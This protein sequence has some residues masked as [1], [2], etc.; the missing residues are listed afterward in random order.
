MKQNPQ[1]HLSPRKRRTFLVL[2]IAS[3]FVFF[4]LLELGLR[5]IQYGPNLSLLRTQ[6]IGERAYHVMNPDVKVRYFSR[7]QFNP[8]SSQDY[9]LVPKPVGTFR[10][11]C[12]GG[13]TTVGFPY[14][15]IGSFSTFLRDRLK[16]LF[17]EK[18][19]EIINLGMTATN[20]FTVLDM[21]RELVDYQPDM[22]IVYDGHNEFYGALGIASNESLGSTR[23]LTI[24]SLKLIHFKSSLL[25]RDAIG[26]ITGV[27]SGS[28]T[29]DLGGTMMER[30]ARGQLVPY[31]ST[32]YKKALEIFKENLN[33][34]KSICKA[35]SI[36]L[37]LGS[38]VSNLRTQ[39]PFV[40]DVSL[41][42]TPEKRLA[43]NSS[44][45][46]G[47]AQQLNGDFDSALA[48]FQHALEHDSLHAETHYQVA[49]TLDT[50]GFK[51]K[52]RVEYLM[53]RD[54]DNLRFRTSS[55]FNEAIRNAAEGEKMVLVDVEE[56]FATNSPDSIPGGELIL[57]HLHPNVRGYF[58]IAKA[59][60]EALRDHEFIASAEEWESRDT[61]S[62]KHLW[63]ERTITDL[64]ERI[65]TR[66]IEFL[67]SGWPF[68]PER[69][70]IRPIHPDDTLGN[71]VEQ[72]V[73]S[74]LVWEQAHIEAAQY[75]ETRGDIA[76]AEQQY[77]SII[78]QIPL[79]V[80][81]YLSLGQ[82]YL[83]KGRSVDA[84]KILLAS[85]DIEKTPYAYKALGAISV[86][87][88][89]LTDAIEF[90]RQAFAFSQ[91]TK[92]R[93]ENGYLLALAFNRAGE[94]GEAIEQLNRVLT[95]NPSYEPAQQS[96]RL[97]E[98][99]K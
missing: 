62:D 28:T 26:T 5:V 91:T 78:N 17:P 10:I 27:F 23:L 70:E 76:N 19:I 94:R 74:K 25:L 89:K 34:L 84:R 54:Y 43:F 87:K 65:G 42:D 49:R 90:L 97:L 67:I 29:D 80:S 30:L 7:F 15:Y 93:T 48:E 12:L 63:R 53:A 35:H 16:A 41:L 59:Y 57:E 52:A 37:M 47:L 98:S 83:R 14:G 92:E 75:Y 72:V 46:R 33:D 82:F 13:S 21:A 81:P 79:N 9:F 69:K 68:V 60:A 71:I 56:T 11:F 64:D 38:Q 77:L 40:S 36:P 73:T 85:L 88:G 45:N 31:N 39:P 95:I 2:T 18:S 6:Q 61:I 32:T 51:T 8:N 99:Q 22:F 50:L 3:P 66:R 20:S 96:L 86:D 44:L 55:D 24:L 58:L 4:L 1:E